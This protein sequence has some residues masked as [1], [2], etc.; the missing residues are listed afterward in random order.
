MDPPRAK[1]LQ[2]LLLPSAKVKVFQRLPVPALVAPG[3]FCSPRL[4]AGLAEFTT[5]PSPGSMAKCCLQVGM[6]RV[7]GLTQHAAIPNPLQRRLA[8]S[9]RNTNLDKF[10][11]AIP[12]SSN[13]GKIW[14]KFWICIVRFSS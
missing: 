5:T 11:H 1:V 9:G 13:T 2:H 10:T 12:A 8:I 6:Q 7:P 14:M 3:Q 4:L